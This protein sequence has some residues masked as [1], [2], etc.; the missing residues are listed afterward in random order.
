[1]T[2]HYDAQDEQDPFQ[3]HYDAQDEQ[4]PNAFHV[5][6]CFKI[7]DKVGKRFFQVD[8]IVKLCS[9]AHY[10][11]TLSIKEVSDRSPSLPRGHH[12]QIAHKWQHYILLATSFDLTGSNSALWGSG[13]YQTRGLA[14]ILIVNTKVG[15]LGTQGFP[16]PNEFVFK[17]YGRAL[18]NLRVLATAGTSGTVNIQKKQCILKWLSFSSG[19]SVHTVRVPYLRTA[20]Y[21]C[22]FI[23]S[24]LMANQ[25]ESKCICD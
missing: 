17:Q 23:F 5:A 6:H 11:G 10:I 19:A 12:L 2:H 13:V 21:V 8:S 14:A 25:G 15:F 7:P 24:C 1:M 16:V 22:A 4:D 3:H 20:P 18:Y 9:F